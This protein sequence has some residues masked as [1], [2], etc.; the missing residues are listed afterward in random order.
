MTFKRLLG[1]ALAALILFSPTA[2]AVEGKYDPTEGLEGSPAEGSTAQAVLLMDAATGTVLW[3]DNADTLLEPASV[4]KI[5]TMLLVCEAIDS[6]QLRPDQTVTASAHAA[7]MGGSQVYLEEGEQM[8]VA[9]LLKAVAVASGNDAAVALGEAVA[10]SESAFVALMNRRAG[11]L[12]MT[13]TCFR[14]CT[15]LPAE[16]H[17]TTARDIAL[18]SRALL[19]HDFIRQFTSIWMDSLRDGAFG[20]SSTNKLL[21]SY[22]GCT[23]LKTGFTSTAGYCISAS[24]RRGELELVAVVLGAKDSKDRFNTA[25]ALLDWGFANF[26]LVTVT[27]EQWPDAL[28]VKLGQQAAVALERPEATLLIHSRDEGELVTRLELPEE[29]EA[30]LLPG[31]TVGHF[32]VEIAGR[33][34]CTLPIVTAQGVERLRFAGVFLDYLKF[35]FCGAAGTSS[36]FEPGVLQ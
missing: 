15:G 28:P 3:E 10:G 36:H 22:E 29:A 24:A 6:G 32:T 11:E 18:M 30:P 5:M 16:G 19:E 9:E 12:G 4:T 2:F 17:L 31:D 20:L 14:N 1:A 23:G 7:G 13:R 21:R 35:L 33:T 34:A 27:P 26:R 25:A 8:T